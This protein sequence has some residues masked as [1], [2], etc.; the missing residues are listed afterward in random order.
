MNNGWSLFEVTE[1]RDAC[2]NQ[3]EKE[4]DEDGGHCER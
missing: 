1:S 3:K 4:I 2:G